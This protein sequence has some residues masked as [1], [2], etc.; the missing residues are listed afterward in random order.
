MTFKLEHLTEISEQKNK[1]SR[2]KL[3]VQFIHTLKI[4][5]QSFLSTNFRQAINAYPKS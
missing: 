4:L 2:Q 3:K 5:F 1:L